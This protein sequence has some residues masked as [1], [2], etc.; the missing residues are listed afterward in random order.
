MKNDLVLLRKTRYIELLL[1]SFQTFCA[2]IGRNIGHYLQI[3]RGCVQ[4]TFSSGRILS[5]SWRFAVQG[6]SEIKVGKIKMHLKIHTWMLL[7][8]LYESHFFHARKRCGLE[9]TLLPNSAHAGVLGSWSSWSCRSRALSLLLSQAW[10]E[11]IML[12]RL[13][14]GWAC[15][16]LLNRT[17][18]SWL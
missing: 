13:L 11:E 7:I 8:S 18:P 3:F 14:S 4:R 10:W 2:V 12:K 1:T 15:P 5:A 9:S 16:S 17:Y 6:S